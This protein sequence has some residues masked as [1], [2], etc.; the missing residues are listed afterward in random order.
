MEGLWDFPDDIKVIIIPQMIEKIFNSIRE[1]NQILNKYNFR[2]DKLS[3]KE[4]NKYKKLINNIRRGD[5]D[6]VSDED[7]KNIKLLNR[8]QEKYDKV[9]PVILRNI[10]RMKQNL[11]ILS[12]LYHEITVNNKR[13]LKK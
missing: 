3:E 10:K 1:L 12:D 6:F 7:A 11:K 13:K 8:N 9:S 5:M 2:V 4:L